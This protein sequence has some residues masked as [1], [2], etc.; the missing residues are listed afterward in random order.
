MGWLC[1]YDTYNIAITC[2]LHRSYTVIRFVKYRVIQCPFWIFLNH[3]LCDFFRSPAVDG[4]VKG[5]TL[6]WAAYV[7]MMRE[8]WNVLFLN[9][10]AVYFFFFYILCCK[11]RI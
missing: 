2:D 7:A 11:L 4:E 1:R 8:K 6:H 3:E 5:R 9:I 10:I